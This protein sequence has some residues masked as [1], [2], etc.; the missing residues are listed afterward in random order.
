LKTF[1]PTKKMHTMIANVRFRHFLLLF[2]PPLALACSEN[3]PSTTEE[4]PAVSEEIPAEEEDAIMLR[5]S[6]DLVADP[7][8]Q[9]QKDRNAI[10]NYAIDN[11]LDVQSTESQLYY[12]VLRPGEGE[13]IEWGDRLRA[14]YKG[15]FLDGKVFDSSY[16]R[17]EPLEFYLGNTIPGWNEGLE[18]INV[19]GKIL[20][21]VP[22]HLGY[23]EEGLKSGKKKVLVPPHEVLVF[24]I[25]VLQKVG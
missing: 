17:D 14:H 11:V 4:E 21:L 24:E 12:Q 22:S 15:Y 20:L 7:Q 23:G 9:G 10:I 25:E 8:S 18:K 6:A 1:F 5:L 2:L 16:R 3:A 13:P 19:G